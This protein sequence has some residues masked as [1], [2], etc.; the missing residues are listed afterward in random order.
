MTAGIAPEDAFWRAFRSEHPEVDLVLLPDPALTA[1]PSDVTTVG[2]EPVERVGAV[3]DRLLDELDD[4]LAGEAGWPVVVPR[5]RVWRRDPL[6]R[7]YLESRLVVGDLEPGQPVPLL[8]AV[9]NAFLAAG[10]R[11]RP[12]PSDRPRLVARRGPFRATAAVTPDA[13]HVILR[14]GLLP[15]EETAR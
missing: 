11:A 10:W 4:H 15:A 6:D 13:L 7:P 5:T 12:L 2:P 14:S 1:R 9:G 3:A 8:R